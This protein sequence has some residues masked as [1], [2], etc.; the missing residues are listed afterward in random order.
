MILLMKKLRLAALLTLLLAAVM[1]SAPAFAACTDT[2]A[3]GVDWQRCYHDKRHF[4]DVDLTG[5]NLRGGFFARSD[6]SGADLSGIDGRRAKFVTTVMNH[7][8]FDKAR[9]IGTDFT[10]A[11]LA[12]TSFREADLRRAKF[13][14]AN[15]RGADFTGAVLGGTDFLKADLSGA[16]WVD[17]TTICPEGSIGQCN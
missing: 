3:P 4:K 9:L 6:F 17:G 7:T 15:L 14:R 2:P 1:L 16:T 8:R 12:G 10:T 13:F 11:E 5:A